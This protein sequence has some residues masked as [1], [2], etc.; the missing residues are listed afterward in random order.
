MENKK[1]ILG[2]SGGVDSSVAAYL[3]Q[4]EGWEVVG[5][6]MNCNVSGKSKLRS[7]IDWRREERDLKRICSKLGIKY[8]VAD[9]EIGYDKKVIGKMVE[10]YRRGLTPNP[11]TLCNKIGKFPKMF[12]LMKKLGASRIATGHY[13]RM[14]GGKLYSGKDKTRDQSYFLIDVDKKYLDKCLFPVG[15]MTKNEVRGLAKRLG[16][17]NWNKKG[18]RGICYLG[19]IDVKGLIRERLGE[20]EGEIIFDGEVIGTHRG[21]WFFTIGEK[22]GESKGARLNNLGRKYSGKRLIVGKKR[23]NRIYVFVDGDSRLMAR[24]VW[25]KG[26]HWIGSPLRSGLKARIRHLGELYGGKLV[27][28]GGRLGWEFSHGVQGVAPGQ[29][30]VFYSKGRVVGGGEIRLR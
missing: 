11:D 18:R 2:M 26:F 12:E 15:E 14:K 4:R 30:I 7:A 19:K 29:S 20:K 6:F 17:R 1:V 5:F 27:K 9:C 22:I 23:G 25:I 28:R 24:K 8:V 16:F 3:L 13:A 10:D 21:Q